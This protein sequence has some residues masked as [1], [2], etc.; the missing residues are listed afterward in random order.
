MH[1]FQPHFPAAAGAPL[2][3]RR[4]GSPRQGEADPVSRG[5]PARGRAAL[6]RRPAF[7]GARPERS[8]RAPGGGSARERGFTLMEMIISL[9]LFGLIMIILTSG[10]KVVFDSWLQSGHRSFKEQEL[11]SLNRLLERQIMSATLFK[12]SG[13]E[14]ARAIAFVGGPGSVTFVTC[15]SLGSRAKVGLWFVRYSFQAASRGN[16]A[17]VSQEWPALEPNWW[18]SNNPPVPRVTLLS[19]LVSG[20]FSYKKVDPQRPSD[21]QYLPDWPDAPAGKAPMSILVDL[22]FGEYQVQ[23]EIPLACALP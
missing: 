23:W 14:R 7:Q 22:N 17:L 19:G 15:E 16:V 13:G 9:V 12:P 2:S 8:G 3:R 10:S 18:L 6:R 20:K 1:V 5:E 11:W 4:A 21:S